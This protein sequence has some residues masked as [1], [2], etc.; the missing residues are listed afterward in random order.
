MRNWL[1]FQICDASEYQ[2]ITWVYIGAETCIS[3]GIGNLLRVPG[4][5]KLHESTLAQTLAFHMEWVI[6]L[7]VSYNFRKSA[8]LT[9][10]Y[11]LIR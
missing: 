8:V 11:N 3:C 4:F 2:N 5:V 7:L 6:C 1:L 9:N 10:N